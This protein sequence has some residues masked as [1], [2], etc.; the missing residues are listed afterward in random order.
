MRKKLVIIGIVVAALVSLAVL[1]SRPP[2]A[3][4]SVAPGMSRT[5]VYSLVGQPDGHNENSKGGVRWRSDVIVGRWEL[6][7]F[8]RADDTVGAIGRRWRWNW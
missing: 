3:W 8:F 4:S 2:S 7:V 6:D 1:A 5:S